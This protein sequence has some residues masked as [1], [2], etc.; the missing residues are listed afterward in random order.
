[1]IYGDG[2]FKDPYGEIWELADP[3]VSPGYTSGLRGR[4]NELKIKYLADNDYAGLSS[5]ELTNKIQERIREK[6][7]AEAQKVPKAPKAPPPR[8]KSPT[9]SVPW[10]TSPPAPATKAHP[11][12]TFKAISITTL[13]STKIKN[14][15]FK[16]QRAIIEIALLFLMSGQTSTQP[17]RILFRP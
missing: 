15:P 3:V 8:A 13:T 10:Q 16:A 4:P 14:N 6:L 12:F 11:S 7:K 17:A 9:C 2:A 1:M 5:E